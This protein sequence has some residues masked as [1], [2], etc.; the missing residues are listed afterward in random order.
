MRRK[1]AV[2]D[3]GVITLKSNYTVKE[4]IDRLDAKL[5]EKG[6]SVFAR[7]DHA[8]GAA[9]VNMPLR[10]TLLLIFGNAKGGTPL[11]QSQQR[12]GI[13]LPLKALCWQDEVGGVWLSYN[14]MKWLGSRHHLT[15]TATSTIDAL[16][17]LLA[18]LASA[19]AT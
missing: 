8:A 7:I 5:A 14:D 2:S 6:I 9:L 13:D 11:M 18:A 3:D 12:I 19:A 17:G 16:A 4:T 10:P 15:A 1:Y